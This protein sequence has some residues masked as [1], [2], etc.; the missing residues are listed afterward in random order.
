MLNR[1]LASL[2]LCL[3]LLFP[4]LT[5]AHAASEASDLIER[6]NGTLIEVMRNSDRLGY[7]GRFETLAPVLV[8]SFNFPAMARISLGKHWRS[9][10]DAQKKEI[11][12][13]FAQL[14]VATFAT[15][16]KAY[17]G[18]SFQVLGEEP[19]RNDSVLVRNQLTKRSGET[20]SLNYVLRRFDG[21]MRII[22][23]STS[24]WTPSTASSP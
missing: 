4:A 14:S 2:A 5:P 21:R 23:F 11:T 20:V 24:I 19:Q 6:L 17:S 18:Q 10:D 1:R 7:S 13:R 16:F 3:S 22:F 12:Q 15:R 9:L 8:E